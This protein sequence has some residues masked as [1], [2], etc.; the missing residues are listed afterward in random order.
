ML[1]ERRMKILYRKNG[2]IKVDLGNEL[3]WLSLGCGG[4]EFRSKDDEYLSELFEGVRA[5][6]S[7]ISVEVRTTWSIVVCENGV[8]A[9][10]FDMDPLG[11]WWQTD[12]AEH[13]IQTAESNG[14]TTLFVNSETPADR[15]EVQDSYRYVKV[16]G[17]VVFFRLEKRFYN[18]KD[19]GSDTSIT[20]DVL[21]WKEVDVPS[22]HRPALTQMIDAMK[23]AEVFLVGSD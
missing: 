7:S 3:M 8:A 9:L 22:H 14:R 1:K 17:E 12:A 2:S 21:A 16:G 5:V 10:S 20:Y 19:E 11:N 13:T 15:I 6:S 18:L 4:A 23:S